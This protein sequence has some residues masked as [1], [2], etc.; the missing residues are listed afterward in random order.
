MSVFFF[1]SRFFLKLRRVAIRKFSGL[2]DADFDKKSWYTSFFSYPNICSIPEVFWN[3]ERFPYEIFWFFWD[4]N[5]S[6]EN[7]EIPLL[8]VS[9]FQKLISS[10]TDKGCHTKFFGTVRH[11]LCRK[12]WYTPSSLF[13]KNFRCPNFSET[14]EDSPKNFFGNA[15]QRLWQTI[16]MNPP[17]L[18]SIKFSDTGSC[19]KQRRVS[20]WNFLVLWDNDFG[21]NRDTTPSSLIK[22]SCATRNFL[23]HQS[24]SARNFSALWNKKIS[25]DNSEVPLLSINFF[26]TGFFPKHRRVHLRIFSVLWDK[27]LEKK[28]WQTP[29]SLIKKSCATRNFLKH[30]SVSA[31]TFS[32]LWNKKISTD[33]SELPLLSVNFYDT[34]F[35]LKHRRFALRKI[36]VLW[37][38]DFDKKSWYTPLFSHP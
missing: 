8:S 32:A 31:R 20:L 30:R 27:I 6:T 36:W 18:L 4:K 19:L 23:Q 26:D 35:F 1:E 38:T 3:T 10:E 25:T 16:V 13:H 17:L 14:K 24:V 15:R 7:S 12:S 34:R 5:L 21:K 2:W 28:S 33:N 22:K 29:S 37:D 9:F 11:R